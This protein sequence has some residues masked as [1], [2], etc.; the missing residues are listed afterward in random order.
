MITAMRRMIKGK[1]AQIIV[2][3]IVGAVGFGF[4]LPSLF[5]NL[6][7]GQWIAT[8]NGRSVP[9]GSFVRKANEEGQRIRE[10]R[11][12]Y[13]KLADLFMQSM[14]M[15]SDPKEIALNQIV[16]EELI[17]QLAKKIDLHIDDEYLANMLADRTFLYRELAGLIPPFLIDPQKGIKMAELK[18]YLA[19]MGLSL[20]DFY[21][22]VENLL[23][24]S[25]V[26]NLVLGASHVLDFQVRARYVQENAA[27]SF[28]V[29]TFDFDTYLAKAKKETVSKE[30]LKKF[31]NKE[32][33]QKK[34]Y[35]VP[36]KRSGKIWVFD[37][38]S[39]GVGADENALKAYYED[40]KQR[41]YVE[42]P[43]KIQ[44]RRIL[45]GFEK[46]EEATAAREKAQKVRSELLASPDMF[47]QKAKEISDDKETAGNGGMLPEFSRG[48]YEREFEMPAFLL[49]EDGAISEVV[50]TRAGFEIIQRV[51]R[52]PAVVK[53]FSSVKAEIKK[54][55]VERKFKDQF[56]KDMKQSIGGYAIGEQAVQN[57]LARAKTTRQAEPQEKTDA[58][59]SKALFRT[60]EGE[61]AFYTDEDKG[62]IVQT[63]EIKKR[64]LPVLETI[65]DTVK[66]D[67]YEERADKML[68]REL[69]KAREKAKKTTFADLQSEFQAKTSTIGLIKPSDT[70]K[71]KSL[72]QKGIP[73]SSM[74]R[75][76]KEGGIG[77]FRADVN[78]YLFKLDKI[79][80]IDEADL[81]EKKDG[82]RRALENESSQQIVEALVA[83]LQQTATIKVNESIINPRT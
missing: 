56:Y 42:T 23:K 26:I 46:P 69:K 35:W 44:V 62:F 10:L 12:Q 33:A 54:H 49:K 81:A 71:V 48:K 31:F 4:V 16:R 59:L 79:G 60:K 36:E 73:I 64:Y 37:S 38:A 55:L 70:E 2:L 21:R 78:G 32:N 61:F 1:L 45:I 30:E 53:P 50:K 80:P 34:R 39:Y 68:S 3:V 17:D 57:I 67:L 29:L 74:F 11:A 24:R 72:S 14:G 43:V 18:V 76:E 83:F 9:Y 41:K 8:V 20:S 40:N 22:E 51:K 66:G 27:K 25:L 52:I 28:S 75:L 7:G 58:K 15:S 6:G 82:I 63:T 77:D 13:G 5:Q 65:Q 47:A 19:R